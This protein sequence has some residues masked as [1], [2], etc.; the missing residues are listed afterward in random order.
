MTTDFSQYDPL[1][2]AEEQ[3]QFLAGTIVANDAHIIGVTSGR[4]A[5]GSTNGLVSTTSLAVSS[6]TVSCA[7]NVNLTGNLAHN[8]H[9]YALPASGEF[10]LATTVSSAAYTDIQGLAEGN[11]IIGGASTASAQ[12]SSAIQVSGATV[13]IAGPTFVGFGT[14]STTSS[15][16]CGGTTVASLS[17]SGAST[18]SSL[19]VAN[20]LTADSLAVT[21][22]TSGPIICSSLSSSGTIT[23]TNTFAC[24]SLSVIPAA[25]DNS[26]GLM[27]TG[28]MGGIS[29]LNNDV[30]WN[31]FQDMKISTMLPETSTGSC[32]MEILAGQAN[33]AFTYNYSLVATGGV[34]SSSSIMT[35]VPNEHAIYKFNLGPHVLAAQSHY[36]VTIEETTSYCKPDLSGAASKYISQFTGLGDHL[37]TGTF[38]KSQRVGNAGVYT[39]VAYAPT[40]LLLQ[41]YSDI[42]LLPDTIINFSGKVTISIF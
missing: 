19:A 38:T 16:V 33:Y 12:T 28:R 25:T 4:V 1:I 8:G 5:V 35:S 42:T 39:V 15:L 40:H 20:N 14:T 18:L 17:V 36:I 37:A 32:V 3:I 29:N 31:G 11:I 7:G 34:S 27:Q 23:T 10:A 9:V 6:G 26:S 13:T 22:L 2:E 24:T 21:A 41:P 30:Y